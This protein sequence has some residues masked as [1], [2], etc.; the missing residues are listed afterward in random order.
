M[1][2]FEKWGDLRDE[3]VAEAGGEEAVAEAGKRVQEYIDDHRLA[4][5][6]RTLDLT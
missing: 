2:G 6:Q 5:R 1:T 3:A 4:E